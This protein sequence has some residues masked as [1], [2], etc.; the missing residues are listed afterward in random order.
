MK[1]N[2][3]LLS[4]EAQ[5]GKTTLLQSFCKT[6]SN[7]GGL[8]TPVVNG[9]RK[10]YNICTKEV[11]NMEAFEEEEQLY[12]GK[13]IFSAAAFKKGASQLLAAS[14]QNENEY[15][16]VDEVGPLEIRL[17]QGFYAALQEILQ[18][19]LYRTLILVV[20]PSLIRELRLLPGLQE[21]MLLSIAG[22][23]DYFRL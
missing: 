7:T 11:F 10:F 8:L 18:S 3:V 6:Y 17:Q 13:Y 22:C 5:S 4:G 2:I 1:H 15:L 16:I 20:R 9:K 21:T 23:K 12:V 19:G 14:K